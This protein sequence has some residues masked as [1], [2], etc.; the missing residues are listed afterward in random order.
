MDFSFIN[1]RILSIGEINVIQ[2]LPKL[3]KIQ[4]KINKEIPDEFLAYYIITNLP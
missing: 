4:F 1:N 3:Q 2:K